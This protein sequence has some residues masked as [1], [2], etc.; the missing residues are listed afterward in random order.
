M[1]SYTEL[2]SDELFVTDDYQL[3]L[4]HYGDTF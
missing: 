2:I 4:G 1:V 3:T